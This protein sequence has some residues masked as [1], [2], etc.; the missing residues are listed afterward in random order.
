MS[1][2][3]HYS[4]EARANLHALQEYLRDEAGPVVAAR[5]MERLTKYCRSLGG[6]L[7]TGH[8]R[9]DLYPGLLTRTF[10]KK[11]VIAFLVIDR[12]VHIVAVHGTAQEWERKIRENPPQLP[13]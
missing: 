5:Y 10:E 13:E 12:E 8:A 2:E 9:D 7:V 4:P 3:V 1:D 6:P 11:R